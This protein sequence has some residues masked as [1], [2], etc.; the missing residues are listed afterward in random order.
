MQVAS[1]HLYLRVSCPRAADIEG[2]AGGT[3]RVPFA[4]SGHRYSR[5]SRARARVLEAPRLTS[6]MREQQAPL[7]TSITREISRCRVP[8]GISIHE[9][10]MC[11]SNRGR[12]PAGTATHEH[13]VREQQMEGD[14]SSYEQYER[15]RQRPT[16]SAG[17]HLYSRATCAR[18]ADVGRQQAPLLTSIMSSI[19]THEHHTREQQM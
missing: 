3:S 1:G 15:K 2:L 10:I 17:R 13:H 4:S 8:A 5:A 6:T 11:E 7:L 19:S 16:E 12:E 18:A 9:R 14:I